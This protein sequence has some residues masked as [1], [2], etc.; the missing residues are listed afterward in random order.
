MPNL[1][2]IAGCNGAGKT[3]A[4]YTILP[5]MLN[6]KEFVNADS[7]A[8]GLSPFNPD[9]VAIQAG[10]IMLSRID[11]LLKNGDDFAIETTLATKSYVSLIK[12]ARTIG[13]KITMVFFWLRSPQEAK[14]RVATRVSK[15]GHHIPDEIVDRRYFKGIYNLRHLYIA[16]CDYWAVFNNEAGSPELV[17]SG[18]FN[19]SQMIFNSDIWDVI[20]KQSDE[21]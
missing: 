20:K 5:E 4:S 11:A 2:I 15:G 13:Y 18:E 1:Y 19:Q 12:N 16:I 8:A 14:Q 9:N 3:T 6:C 10:R 7:I 21:T 17:I